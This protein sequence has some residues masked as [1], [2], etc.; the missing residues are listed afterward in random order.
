MTDLAALRKAVLGMQACAPDGDFIRWDIEYAD[1][2]L[3][4]VNR[5]GVLALLDATQPARPE[6]RLEAGLCAHYRLRRYED[7]RR[8][9]CRDCGRPWAETQREIVA[10]AALR[11]AP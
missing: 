6:G 10:R 1:P 5:Q 2:A 3:H 4:Y 11:D 9:T 7:G 8:P